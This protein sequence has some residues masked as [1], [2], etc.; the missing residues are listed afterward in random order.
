MAG[1]LL[2]IAAM[3]PLRAQPFTVLRNLNGETGANPSG[4]LLVGRDGL[5]YGTTYL[6]GQNNNG[7]VFRIN[8]DGSGLA[9]IHTFKFSSDGTEPKAGLTQGS[10]GTLYGTLLTNGPN[11]GGGIVFKLDPDGSKYD[12]PYIIDYRET[13]FKGSGLYSTPLIANNGRLY[14]T[15][16]AGASGAG[17]LISVDI[18]SNTLPTVIRT[19][20]ASTDGGGPFAG[21]IQGR[22]S[23][24]YGSTSLFGP[25]GG[26]TVF[27]VN[28]DG[29]GFAVLR[30][31]SPGADGGSPYGALLQGGDGRLYGTTTTGGSGG[32]G[33]V[34]AMNTDG[35]GFTVLHHLNPGVEGSSPR[36]ALI[37]G[38]DGMLY[39]T[40]Y[41]GGPAG[42]GTVFRLNPDGSGFTVLKAM[43][44]ADGANPYAGLA[45]GPDGTLFGAASN[46]GAFNG[47]T[48]FR[49]NPDGSG[50]SV[51]FQ[52]GGGGDGGACYG[53]LIQGADG[54]L[55]GAAESGG[56]NGAGT[57]F[58]INTDGSGFTVLRNMATAT[59]GANPPAPLFQGADG[60]LYGGSGPSGGANGLG[61]V[62]RLKP[63]GGDFSVIRQGA[64]ATGYRLVP[65][66]RQAADGTLYGCM[67]SDS[68]S[69]GGIIFSMKPDGSGY[70]PLVN[71]GT[72][73]TLSTGRN[74]AGSITLA[75]DGF[76]YGATT[77]YGPLG[78]GTIFKLQRDGAGLTILGPGQDAT[79]N[80]PLL[81][82]AD[83]A[84]YATTG[85]GLSGHGTL[86]RIAADT[87]NFTLLRSLN[88]NP[89]GTAPRGPL[90]RA[91]DGRL[92]GTSTSGGA[93]GGGTLFRINADGSGFQVLWSFTAATDGSG[94]NALVQGADGI[95]YGVT[96]TGGASGSGTLFSFVIPQAPI[97]VQQPA[98]QTVAAGASAVFSLAAAGT[99]GMTYQWLLNGVPIASATS[100][101]LVVPGASAANAGSYTCLVT[102]AGGSVLST[103][104]MLAVS[105]TADPGRLINLS[106]RADVGTGDKILIAGFVM[107]GG[108]SKPMLLRAVGPGLATT[109]NLGGT[110]PNPVLTLFDSNQAEIAQNARWGG[111][112]ALADAMTAVG[113][114]PLLPTSS[115]SVLYSSLSASPGFTAEV[116]DAGGGE[117]VALAEIYDAGSGGPPRLANLSARAGVGTGANVLIAGFV[118]GG[119]TAKTVL[120]RAV[121]PGLATTFNLG[122]TLAHPR[123]TLF[124]GNQNLIQSN[125]AWG[126]DPVLA[127]IMA[128]V[129]AFPLLG[130]SQD[131]ALL[132]TLA[133]GGYTAQVAGADGGSGIALV[134]I[135]DVP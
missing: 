107:S 38:S 50:F 17:T 9:V 27:K 25:N 45:Q 24:L 98:S 12:E 53:P 122:G 103:A 15:A 126:G 121:G 48:V 62:F 77:S 18:V 3:V 79:I 36:S 20:T 55:Y 23:I 112:T 72:S 69:N 119:Q 90:I 113:A 110:L 132:V 4:T 65:P 49:M 5:L 102:N 13:A 51:M 39:G 96:A 28:L 74:L 59:D 75:D 19:L 135:Y 41:S 61:T 111:S 11:T 85:T 70:T 133:P 67:E 134:E 46:G 26:G 125:T 35:S 30:S 99:E 16:E 101:T 71:F 2:G 129:G 87:A 60:M 114:F 86:V 42:G 32:G 89:D 131:S 116:A 22:D 10:D 82:G 127:N 83:G 37:Q 44:G 100:A 21:L 95:L 57:L 40:A 91:R 93:N 124:D 54:R 115:D 128:S 6:G 66:F 94:A 63:D 7:T 92:Y 33:T 43:G 117:G 78:A 47:G 105:N 123:L 14:C 106:A 97:L 34:F 8:P 68:T 64:N 109:F 104:A 88:G 56:S 108:G 52:M 1:A 76:L 120:I 118:I 58:A 29:S 130:G 80:G 84:F 81:Q 31:L 73:G